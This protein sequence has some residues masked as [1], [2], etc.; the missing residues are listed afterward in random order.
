MFSFILVKVKV[1]NESK[2]IIVLKF[3]LLSVFE[4]V[5]NFNL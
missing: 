2:T 4:R 3:D 5:F 1:K